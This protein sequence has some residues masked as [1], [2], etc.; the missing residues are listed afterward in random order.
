MAEMDAWVTAMSPVL[1]INNVIIVYSTRKQFHLT[2]WWRHQMETFFALL[3]ICAE[4]S[5]VTGEVPT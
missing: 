2:P 1:E 4:N 3:A 5:S